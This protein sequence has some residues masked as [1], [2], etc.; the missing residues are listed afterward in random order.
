[1][2]R[3]DILSISA[4]QVSQP[5]MQVGC[6][7]GFSKVSVRLI[8]NG[9][10]SKQLHEIARLINNGRALDN[11]TLEIWLYMSVTSTLQNQKAVAAYFKVT[12]YCLLALHGSVEL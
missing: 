11:T 3:I 1:M 4:E 7:L 8:S 2:E 6:L 9:Y 10:I 12:R 5:D